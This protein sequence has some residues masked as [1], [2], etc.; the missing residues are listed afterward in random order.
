MNG[1]EVG[2]IVASETVATAE[3]QLRLEGLLRE[4]EEEVGV[5]LEV[6]PLDSPTWQP[7]ISEGEATRDEP[8]LYITKLAA[9]D[10][11]VGVGD[12]VTLRHPR[13][14]GTTFELVET[15]VPILGVHP[16]PFRFVAYMDINHA[17]LFNLTGATNLVVVAPAEGTTKDDVKRELFSFQGVSSVQ[18]VAEVADVIDDLLGEFVGVLRV[19]EGAMLLLALLIA[20]NSASIN[21]DERIR[22]HATMFAFGVPVSRV[23]RMAI[24]E[25]L[26]LGAAATIAGTIGGWLLLRWIIA[27]RIPQTLP[28]VDVPP[29]ISTETLLITAALGVV[30]V[31]L[32]PL[33][34]LRKL[35]RMNVPA[36]LKVFE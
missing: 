8:G 5:Q 19:I 2:A 36:A 1:P 23:L 25:N 31:A 24:I 33:L 13:L 6:F 18:G 7:T 34:T 11:G 26:I 14:A 35:Q 28:D 10:L 3:P 15:E 21:M 9:K 32:S 4:G 17:G 16:H 12:T 22:E 20:F 29:V 30:A 27:I